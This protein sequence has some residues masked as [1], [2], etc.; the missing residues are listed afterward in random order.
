MIA[1][2]EKSLAAKLKC[3]RYFSYMATQV[4]EMRAEAEQLRSQMASDN[5]SLKQQRE[6]IRTYESL[7][8]RQRSSRPAQRPA[9][10]PPAPGPEDTVLVVGGRRFVDSRK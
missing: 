10:G 6:T 5:L 2:Y 7:L 3:E 9:A 1:I 4:K 8:R